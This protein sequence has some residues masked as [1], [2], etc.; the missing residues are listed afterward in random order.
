MATGEIVDRARLL[1][2]VVGPGGE[3]VPDVAANLPGRGL[4]LT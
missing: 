3:I 4:W 2:F 1:R